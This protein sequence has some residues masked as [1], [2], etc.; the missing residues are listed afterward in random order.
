M[1]HKIVLIGSAGGSIF[2]RLLGHA[3]A[4]EAIYEAVSDRDCGFL[5]VAKDNNIPHAMLG[6][7]DGLEFSNRLAERYRD[8]KELIFLCFYTRLFKGEF[9]TSRSG[10]IF[11][12]HPSLLP[13]FRG[14][15][16]F[17]EMLESSAQFLGTTLHLVDE[18]MDTGKILIQVAIPLDR[19]LPVSDNRHKVFMGQYYSVLQFFRW[20]ADGRLVFS[21]DG[22][23]CIKGVAYAPS[24]F[25]PNL[26]SDF[27][28]FIGEKNQIT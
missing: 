20:L 16:G 15:K 4:R 7:K 6:A 27:F 28:E 25:S 9:L 5:Q 17:Q 18:G 13:S 11:N 8:T 21:S 3:F 2:S 23:V 22:C 1:T 10:F 12:C 24:I 19:S 26:D 14:L